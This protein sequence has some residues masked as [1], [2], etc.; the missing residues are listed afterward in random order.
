MLGARLCVHAC[1]RSPPLAV[2]ITFR[3]AGA[4][5]GYPIC[6]FSAANLGRY[7]NDNGGSCLGRQR[8]IIIGKA[9][10]GT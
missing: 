10:G 9:R 8:V 4:S 6:L 1:V 7:I 5:A 2:T 3:G